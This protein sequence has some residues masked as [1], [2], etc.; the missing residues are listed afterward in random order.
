[1][2]NTKSTSGSK[3]NSTPE[4]NVWSNSKAASWKRIRISLGIA[5]TILVITGLVG[6]YIYSANPIKKSENST[7]TINY[8]DAKYDSLKADK[9]S[10]SDDELNK[11]VLQYGSQ[12]DNVYTTLGV[13]DPTKWMKEDVN[14]AYLAL[15]Y[16]DKISAFTQAGRLL[17]LLNSA[18]TNGVDIF[19]NDFGIGQQKLDVIAKRTSDRI[20]NIPTGAK[21]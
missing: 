7:L 8:N 13:S 21:K 5:T 4:I 10:Y 9:P 15:L 19:N 20:A 18:R 1:M 12:F 2:F 14:K 11:L 3:H 16:A 6:A 17:G